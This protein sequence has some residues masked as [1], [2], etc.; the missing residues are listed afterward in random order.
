M[1][2]LAAEFARAIA[3]RDEDVDLYGA[4]MMIASVGGRRVDR[5]RYAAWLD[6]VAE[7]IREDAGESTEPGTLV[8]AIDRQLFSVLGFGGNATN[9]SDPENSYLD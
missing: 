9:Y 3:G 8:S 1:S 6:A 4:V 7:L 2:P 5:H